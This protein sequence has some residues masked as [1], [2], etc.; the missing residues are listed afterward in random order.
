M[1][2]TTRYEAFGEIKEL[3]LVVQ[4][5]GYTVTGEDWEET[6]WV[7]RGEDYYAMLS[8]QLRNKRVR[9]IDRK[10]WINA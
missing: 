1:T 3:P 8:P 2:P 7:E 4:V 10:V 9:I 5:N 6:L